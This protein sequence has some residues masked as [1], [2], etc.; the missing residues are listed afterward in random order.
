MGACH[1]RERHLGR[2]AALRQAGC[3][4]LRG[5]E[6]RRRLAAARGVREQVRRE[7]VHRIRLHDDV[8]DAGVGILLRVRAGTFK[9]TRIN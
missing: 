4:P 3:Q 2:A 8:R 1:D 7:L 9:S 5:D 6:R